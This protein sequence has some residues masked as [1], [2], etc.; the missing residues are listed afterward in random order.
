MC[1]CLF[2]CLTEKRLA[3]VTQKFYRNL[4]AKHPNL[5]PTTTK[6]E[7]KEQQQNNDG[8]TLVSSP[9]SPS[10]SLYPS[11]TLSAPDDLHARASL[12]SEHLRVSLDLR[13]H[14]HLF[15]TYQHCFIAEEAVKFSVNEGMVKCADEAVEICNTLL[16][17]GVIIP[18]VSTHIFHNDHAWYRFVP[19]AVDFTVHLPTEEE[20]VIS[21]RMK[22]ELDIRDRVSGLFRHVY[23]DSFVAKDA[24]DWLID[25]GISL[26][27]AAALRLC[28]RLMRAQQIMC[29]EQTGQ[30]E[31]KNNTQLYRY[32]TII[33]ISSIIASSLCIN[34]Y[35]H[36]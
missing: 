30:Q 34:V 29:V 27:E 13:P 5:K 3:N 6:D 2:V 31:F 33:I 7:N 21:C 32:N 19:R 18:I 23:K 10:V 20:R 8:A 17:E 36:V 35:S 11:L 28:Q 22:E 12:L 14:K 26:N 9:S 24:V 25:R 16:R 1:V 15:R 4:Y